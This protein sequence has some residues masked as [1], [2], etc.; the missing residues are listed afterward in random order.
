[1]SENARQLLAEDAARID[2][3]RAE[4]TRAR[5]VLAM[6]RPILD[7]VET[8]PGRAMDYVR[9]KVDQVLSEPDPGSQSERR[10]NDNQV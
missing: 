3:L 6:V 10:E 2:R 1:V 5:D 9:A 8:E 4:L 7:R